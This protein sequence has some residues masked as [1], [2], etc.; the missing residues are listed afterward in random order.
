MIESKGQ[1]GGISP[2]MHVRLIVSFCS[3]VLNE[4]EETLVI[5]VQHGRSVVI[6]LRGYRD[7]PILKGT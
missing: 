3:D 4:P 7:P 1:R 6:K 2:G 5:N